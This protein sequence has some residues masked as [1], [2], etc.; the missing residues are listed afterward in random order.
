VSAT[1]VEKSNQGF[2]DLLTLVAHPD[3]F[4]LINQGAR[5]KTGRSW[6]EDA[7][8]INWLLVLDNADPTVLGF[9]QEHL[10]RKIWWGKIPLITCTDIVA[11]TLAR[12]AGK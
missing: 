1:T 8:S 2:T 6:L 7:S 5:L 4:R 11:A 9:L 3:Q 10:P 12:T